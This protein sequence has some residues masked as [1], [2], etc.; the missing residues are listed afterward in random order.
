MCVLCVQVIFRDHSDLRD[1]YT[2]KGDRT[3]LEWH[4]Q[5]C[6]GRIQNCNAG[7]AQLNSEMAELVEERAAISG[8][9]EQPDGSR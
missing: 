7:I 8:K 1:P 3:W 4:V 6:K 9:G 2:S 5:E